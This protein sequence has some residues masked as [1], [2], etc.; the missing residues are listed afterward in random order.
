MSASLEWNGDDLAQKWKEAGM[1]A[2]HDGA[3][4]ILAKAN[5]EETPWASGQLGGSGDIEDRE[6]EV[7]ISFNTPYARR[8]HEE[9]MRHPDPRNPISVAGRKD[10]YLRD[11]VYDLEDEIKQ[12]VIDAIN[13]VG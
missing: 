8:Q 6:D 3:E 13:E 10:H 12:D 5:N 4:K 7:I 9:E 2:L 11:P 1:K